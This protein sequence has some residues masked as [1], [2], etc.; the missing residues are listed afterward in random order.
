MICRISRSPGVGITIRRTLR[1]GWPPVGSHHSRNEARDRHPN[2]VRTSGGAVP[3]HAEAQIVL[4]EFG[5]HLRH[6]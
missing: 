6:A 4:S 1:A 2:L 3:R 5:L